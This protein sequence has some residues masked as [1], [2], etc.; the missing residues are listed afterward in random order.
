M[1]EVAEV[2]ISCVNPSDNL[3]TEIKD[4]QCLESFILSSVLTVEG[5]TCMCIITKKCARA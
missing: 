1:P 4:T 5:S 3:D 2:S